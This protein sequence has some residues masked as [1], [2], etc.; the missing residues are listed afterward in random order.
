MIGGLAQAG[1]KHRGIIIGVLIGWACFECLT[2]FPHY[3]S[4]FNQTVGGPRNGSKWLVDS[5]LDWGQDLPLLKKFS[6]SHGHPALITACFTTA[7]LDYYAG[8]NHQDLLVDPN[9][10][11]PSYQRRNSIDVPVEYL[12]VSATFR[13]GFWLSDPALFAWL[14][15]RTPAEILG[16]SLYIYD[17]SADAESQKNIGVI[18]TRL[19]KPDFAQRQYARAARINKMN[20]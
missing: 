13:E 7:S 18:Y 8:D 4:Y 14:K 15:N 3:L 5:N 16:H 20:L 17:I 10:H 2:S 11:A 9:T 6:E 19:G 12:V 1:F